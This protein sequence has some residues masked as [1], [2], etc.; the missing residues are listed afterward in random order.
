MPL[1]SG[2][3][4]GVVAVA[5]ALVFAALSALHLFWAVR[6][7]GS[8]SAALPQRG[9]TSLFV[10]GRLST[11]V[12]ALLLALAVVVV[13]QRVSLGPALL[14]AGLVPVA[15]WTLT[16]VMILRA[17]GDFRYIGF[18]KRVRDTRF[19]TLDTRFFSP[20]ALML[21]LGAGWGALS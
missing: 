10:P 18:F 8:G 1:G 11:L 20:I 16:T 2:A 15:S 13:L 19:A 21:G 5:T 9:G 7:I 14:P 12:V 17:V 4:I 6:G 3:A